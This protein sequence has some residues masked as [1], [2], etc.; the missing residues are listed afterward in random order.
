MSKKEKKKRF[1]I[2]RSFLHFGRRCTH[3]SVTNYL[4][5]SA[6]AGRSD[7]RFD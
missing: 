4:V 7:C 5:I 2:K 6:R 1:Y 3:S